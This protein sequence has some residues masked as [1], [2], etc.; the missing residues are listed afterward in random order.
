MNAIRLSVALLVLGAFCLLPFSSA[1]AQSDEA[2]IKYR[3][4]VMRSLSDNL[5]G[6]GDILKQ[7]LPY[8]DN[9][10]N[11]AAAINADAKNI[12][13]AFQKK[14]TEGLTDA[15]PEL[16]DDMDE[17]KEKV[18]AL[19]KESAKLIQVAK[20]GDMGAI[21]EQVKATGK[22]CGSCHKEYRK[23][24]EESYKNKM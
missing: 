19:E 6:I 2:Y 24:K 1:F 22:A 18:E 3:Q 4:K 14:V 9:I 13:L 10:V 8:K 16:W 7:G 21:A 20:S 23:P 11:H 12:P 17:L 5:G 15:K